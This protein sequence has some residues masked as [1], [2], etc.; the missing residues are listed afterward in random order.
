MYDMVYWLMSLNKEKLKKLG[1]FVP[2]VDFKSNVTEALTKLISDLKKFG[3]SNA[4]NVKPEQIKL[5]WG[6]H[7][8]AIIDELL[9]LELYRREFQFKDPIIPVDLEEEGDEVTEESGLGPNGESVIMLNG[10][11]GQIEI[12][13]GGNLITDIYNVGLSGTLITK[14]NRMQHRGA[15]ETKINFFDPN[16]RNDE[17]FD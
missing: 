14:K 3:Y 5:G 12:R 13:E 11:G 6:E 8:C 2:Y 10:G 7:V 4:K 15:E 9:N 16:H 17:D 1:V